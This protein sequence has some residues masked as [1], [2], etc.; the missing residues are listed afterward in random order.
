M[1]T[2]LCFRLMH[3]CPVM[4][5]QGASVLETLLDPALYVSLFPGMDPSRLTLWTGTMTVAD[6]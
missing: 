4:A 2:Q 1:N 5:G 3:S 6:L